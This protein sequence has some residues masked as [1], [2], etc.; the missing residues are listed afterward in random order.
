MLPARLAAIIGAFCHLGSFSLPSFLW[1]SGQEECGT[2]A[3]CAAGCGLVCWCTRVTATDSPCYRCMLELPTHEQ[4]HPT[5]ERAVGFC[6]L[7][8]GLTLGSECVWVC[9]NHPTMHL[10]FVCLLPFCQFASFAAGCGSSV[11][12]SVVV[13]TKV[14]MHSE[15]HSSAGFAVKGFGVLRSRVLAS[16]RGLPQCWLQDAGLSGLCVAVCWSGVFVC[17]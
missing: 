4:P 14:T 17:L 10:G 7:L 6:L 8:W 2:V 12:D 16:C 3:G 15:L 5:H 11:A 9:S 1:P 13:L